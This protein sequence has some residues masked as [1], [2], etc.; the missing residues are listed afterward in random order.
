M[1]DLNAESPEE[2]PPETWSL[3]GFE[4]FDLGVVF[5]QFL[6]VILAIPIDKFFLHPVVQSVSAS[7]FFVFLFF[8]GRT[9]Q[10]SAG[11]RKING[12]HRY[13]HLATTLGGITGGTFIFAFVAM[14][15]ADF[16][17]FAGLSHDLGLFIFLPGL[18]FAAG[19]M[20][21]LAGYAGA[22]T[23]SWFI[24]CPI[25]MHW[26]G[27]TFLLLAANVVLMFFYV[28]FRKEEQV[29]VRFGLLTI[30]LLSF[31]IP[32]RVQEMFLRPNG[33]HFQSL[34]QTMIVLIFFGTTPPLF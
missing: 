13:L 11:Y 1:P 30:F 34:I 27:R 22:G 7:G 10:Y 32:V 28:T 12:L 3:L 25:W 8:L 6:L 18:I 23:E 2:Q 15:L 17:R 5:C 31:Y 19:L 33:P 14:P 4:P 26:L 16:L 24:H 9:R 20:P 29:V 21:F